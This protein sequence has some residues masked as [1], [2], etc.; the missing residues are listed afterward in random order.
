M[1][2]ATKEA[3]LQPIESYEHAMHTLAL[4]LLNSV[5]TMASCVT[6]VKFTRDQAHSQCSNYQHIF[7]AV[8]RREISNSGRPCGI[9][10]L[11]GGW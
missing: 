6:A 8:P 5:N 1:L 4:V 2:P 10:Y 11:K 7:H 9:T 3:L